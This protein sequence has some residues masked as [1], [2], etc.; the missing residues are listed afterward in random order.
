MDNT[1]VLHSDAFDF[2]ILVQGVL[3]EVLSEPALFASS[4]GRRHVRFIVGVDENRAGFDSL[5]KP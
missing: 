5:H 4:E 3:A 1:L 2:Q